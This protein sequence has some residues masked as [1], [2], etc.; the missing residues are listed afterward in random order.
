MDK[1]VDDYYNEQPGPL[2]RTDR[3]RAIDIDSLFK[4]LNA[5]NSE[6]ATLRG[7]KE[8]T[9]W[10]KT[11]GAPSDTFHASLNGSCVYV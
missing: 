5:T 10:A 8:I 9:N 4:E 7:E 2:G 1:I 3:K 11:L 6:L